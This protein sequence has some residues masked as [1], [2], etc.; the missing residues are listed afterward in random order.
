MRA[1]SRAF[2]RTHAHVSIWRKHAL[3]GERS[4]TRLHLTQNQILHDYIQHNRSILQ[5]NRM[6]I[7]RTMTTPVCSIT[8]HAHKSLTL[9]RASHSAR[10]PMPHAGGSACQFY[11][12]FYKNISYCG[13][14]T[15]RTK[16]GQLA[17]GLSSK[18]SEGLTFIKHGWNK[19]FGV[20]TLTSLLNWHLH[21]L[22]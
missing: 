21:T 7:E 3:P 16:P 17:T 8:V 9:P 20:S 15:S 10:S 5:T 11:A 1:V 14:K 12:R 4:G 19:D 6:Q 13:L 2:E 22:K 18:H